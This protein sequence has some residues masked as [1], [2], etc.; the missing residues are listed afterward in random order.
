MHYLTFRITRYWVAVGLFVIMF[1][2]TPLL[3]DEGKHLFIL[4]GQSNMRKP[5]P[6]SFGE[7]VQSVFG[8]DK[9]IVVSKAH[10]G[11]PINQWYKNWQPP[12][13]MTLNEKQ[14]RQ[15]NG[16]LYDRLLAAVE[17][18]VKDEQIQTVTFVWM[19]G[20]ADASASW[21][22][23][24]EQSFLGLLEQLKQDLKMDKI[25]FVIGRIND[26]WI[27][28]P[29]GKLVREIQVKLGEE[30]AHGDWINTD[31]LN[32]GVNPWGGYSIDDGHFPP[33]GY[34]VMGK[35]FAERACKLIDPDVNLDDEVFAEHF[36]D[37]ADDITTHA[38]VGKVVSATAPQGHANLAALT[39][40][41][42]GKLD[43]ND[44]AWVEFAPSTDRLDLIIDLGEVMPVESI[45]AHTL[46]SS[47]AKAEFPDAFIYSTSTDGE[48]YTT[49]SSRYN[50]IKF[51]NKKMLDQMRQDGIKPQAI[52]LHNSQDN[53]EARYVKIEIE[54]GEQHVLID[55]II[56]SPR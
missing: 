9:V 19:Q 47:A 18:G 7:A 12:D 26:F 38:A 8:S 1:W 37:S 52:L 45:A 28:Q 35:R 48:D 13:G 36:F 14:A 22:A 25:N 30:H 24:Y 4:A 42:F 50:T 40:S 20:E 29:D 15:T 39:D 55:E 46:I 23:V 51:E 5:L 6:Q 54:T 41:T 53:L 56:V 33:S 21:G 34:V 43:H 11:Q 2:A 27:D 3:A 31:D 10:P 17:R 16:V 44:P 32:R 49:R